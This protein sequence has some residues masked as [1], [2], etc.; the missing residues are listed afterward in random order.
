[1][2]FAE[3]F[4]INLLRLPQRRSG[5]AGGVSDRSVNFLKIPVKNYEDFG[6]MR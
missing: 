6:I 2:P 5:A 1:M 3:A 4:R